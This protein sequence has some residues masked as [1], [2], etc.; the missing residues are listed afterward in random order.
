MPP[1]LNCL[2]QSVKCNEDVAPS[3]GS[4]FAINNDTDYTVMKFYLYILG[5][6]TTNIKSYVELQ[7]DR[8]RK[9][10]AMTSK[11]K[12]EV[13]EVEKDLDLLETLLEELHASISEFNIDGSSAGCTNY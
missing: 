7:M 1:L 9:R 10:S 12:A 3:V 13:P 6:A 5:I 8:T 2:I 11:M 4:V